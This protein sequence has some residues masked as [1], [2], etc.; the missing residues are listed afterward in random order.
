[1]I[2]TITGSSLTSAANGVIASGASQINVESSTLINNGIAIN[3]SAGN[4][5]ILVSNNAPCTTMGPISAQ[6]V[7]Q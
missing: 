1:M 7:L 6:L 5:T 4:A 2:A 3:A